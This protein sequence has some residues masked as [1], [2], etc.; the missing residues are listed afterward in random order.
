MSRQNSGRTSDKR[1]TKGQARVIRPTSRRNRFPS[2][3]VCYIKFR[4]MQHTPS[5][6]IEA[7]AR[8]SLTKEIK[9][10]KFAQE[11]LVCSTLSKLGIKGVELSCSQIFDR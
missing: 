4:A 10:S 2:R 3:R 11:S 8:F 1:W 7:L 5:S 9:C 6:A